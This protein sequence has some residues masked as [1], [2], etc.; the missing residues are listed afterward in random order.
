M[1]SLFRLVDF[2]ALISIL[3]NITYRNKHLY[4]SHT[5]KQVKRRKM[6]DLIMRIVRIWL[7]PIC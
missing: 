2:L 7:T 6:T 1:K 3:S 4:I 5:L